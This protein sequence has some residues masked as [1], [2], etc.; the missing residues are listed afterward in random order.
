MKLNRY[1]QPVPSSDVKFNEAPVTTDFPPLV[2]PQDQISLE[3]LEEFSAMTFASLPEGCQKL[4]HNISGPNITVQPHSFPQLPEAIDQSCKDPSK[5]CWKI[6]KAK[7]DKFG[8]PL[9]TY[10]RIT[11]GDNLVCPHNMP[12]HLPEL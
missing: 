11:V 5:L 1:T 8:D 7:E 3:Q 10:L 6:L 12:S 4:Y 9:E 2:V